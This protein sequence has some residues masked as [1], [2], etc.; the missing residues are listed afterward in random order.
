[1]IHVIA[2][3]EVVDGARDK[4]MALFSELAPTVRAE[5]GCIEYL[6][7][8]DLATEIAGLAPPRKNVVTVIEKWDNPAALAAHLKAPHMDAFRLQAKPLL[9]GVSIQVL[10]SS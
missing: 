8:V 1:M 7:A 3:I 9:A 10:T 6:P 2:T 4:L 5:Q